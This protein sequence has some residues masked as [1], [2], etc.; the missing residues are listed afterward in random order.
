VMFSP[1]PTAM[2]YK[3]GPEFVMNIKKSVNF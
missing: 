3:A 2:V 1:F